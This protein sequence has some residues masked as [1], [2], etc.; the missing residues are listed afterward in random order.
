MMRKKREAVRGRTQLLVG[1]QNRFVRPRDADARRHSL[2]ICGTEPQHERKKLLV[3]GR[4]AIGTTQTT[5][6]LTLPSIM[7]A[8]AQR[9]VTHNEALRVLDSIV[10]RSIEDRN[11]ASPP[12]AGA[13]GASVGRVNDIASFQHGA[14]SFIL[15][16]G[17]GA[18]GVRTRACWWFGMAAL[19]LPP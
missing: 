19:G 13:S 11:L 14:W 7:P 5:S 3:S 15:P 2:L 9:D 17:D 6:N 12:T 10:Q 18:R 8:Q 1:V 16:R 4:L